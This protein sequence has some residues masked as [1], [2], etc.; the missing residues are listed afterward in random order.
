M[1]LELRDGLEE[2]YK[3]L[4]AILNE[5]Y[6]AKNLS[7]IFQNSGYSVTSEDFQGTM[8]CTTPE[9]RP[10][11]FNKYGKVFYPSTILVPINTW[12]SQE[13]G[14]E[15]DLR[16]K[17][18]KLPQHLGC[19]FLY[20]DLNI[21]FMTERTFHEDFHEL[22]RIFREVNTPEDRVLNEIHSYHTDIDHGIETWES[23][24]KAL[25]FY[26][27]FHSG[28]NK[29]LAVDLQEKIDKT[30]DNL[31]QIHESNNCEYVESLLL[32]VSKLD[33]IKN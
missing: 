28:D 2:Q 18:R 16:T 10:Y 30:I 6:I 20:G 17:L 15:K 9:D 14:G 19:A 3:Q 7:T 5:K 11:L 21:K 12:L 32:N 31:R 1:V 25:K 23:V 8:L 4:L 13:E 24:K 33:D 29:E 22:Y 27:T 26:A